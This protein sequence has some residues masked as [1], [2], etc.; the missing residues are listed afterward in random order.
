MRDAGINLDM[1]KPHSVRMASA[2]YAVKKHVPMVTILKTAGWHKETTFSKYY[3][4][5]IVNTY[6]QNLLDQACKNSN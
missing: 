6:D 3:H 4:K 2:S 5:P 1:F